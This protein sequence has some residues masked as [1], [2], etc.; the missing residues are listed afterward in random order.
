MPNPPPNA[1]EAWFTSMF[2]REGAFTM[3]LIIMEQEPSTVT[4]LFGTYLQ[5]VGDELSWSDLVAL[6]DTAESP[7]DIVAVFAGQ[8]EN[9]GLFGDHEAKARMR[10]LE[11]ALLADRLVL[12]KGE[13]FD[14]W[15]R[16]M[17]IERMYDA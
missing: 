11:E 3:F 13:M 12:Q 6:L 4:P 1:F 10:E 15:G 9:G 17:Q 8:D 5:A 2:R 7:W 16:A 14:K